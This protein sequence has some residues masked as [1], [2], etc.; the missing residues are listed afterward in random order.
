M[1][2]FEKKNVLPESARRFL[3]AA[4]DQTALPDLD[5]AGAKAIFRDID[6]DASEAKDFLEAAGAR[7]PKDVLAAFKAGGRPDLLRDVLK[8]G[9]CADRFEGL[10]CCCCG[11]CRQC[12]FYPF[13]R[14][15]CGRIQFKLSDGTTLWAYRVEIDG[16]TVEKITGRPG[17]VKVSIPAVGGG[18]TQTDFDAH[19]ASGDH[20]SRYAPKSHTTEANPH[21]GK[22]A[23]AKYADDTAIE[24]VAKGSAAVTDGVRLAKVSDG[25][26]LADVSTVIHADDDYAGASHDNAAHSVNFV[27]AAANAC[28]VNPATAS[29]MI[30]AM[31]GV[32]TGMT[33]VVGGDGKP[34]AGCVQASWC[35][36]AGGLGEVMTPEIDG[37]SA[38][39]ALTFKLKAGAS[40]PSGYYDRT[41]SAWGSQIVTVMISIPLIPT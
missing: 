38:A 15:R 18:V 8:D 13:C 23:P 39:G 22:F 19:K 24:Y 26:T 36:A 6:W 34:A 2:L 40:A 41:I 10:L 21:S 17:V 28:L 29:E 4:L 1:G 20:D 16:A 12:R 32:P 35:P 9:N 3:G 25:S 5:S 30:T 14:R 27:I 37:L 7:I 33:P 31:L 11:P